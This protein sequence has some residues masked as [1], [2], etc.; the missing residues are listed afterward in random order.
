VP[1]VQKGHLPA[2]AHSH[3]M[4]VGGVEK[5]AEIRAGLVLH[6]RRGLRRGLPGRLALRRR[7]YP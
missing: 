6:W 1:Q 7:W 4:R 3:A 5:M 2:A